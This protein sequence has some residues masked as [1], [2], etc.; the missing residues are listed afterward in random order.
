MDGVR[1]ESGK[2]LIGTKE[3]VMEVRTSRRRD[4]DR[5]KWDS[6]L[7]EGMN[8]LPFKPD[9]GTDSIN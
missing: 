9:P 8:G 7:L 4:G 3:G 1:E 6:E 5:L 2:T